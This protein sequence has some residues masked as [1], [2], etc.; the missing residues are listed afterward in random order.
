MAAAA[1]GSPD[2]SGTTWANVSLK[3]SSDRAATRIEKFDG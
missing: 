1:N 2:A 3:S